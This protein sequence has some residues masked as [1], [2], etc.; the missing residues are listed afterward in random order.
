M[1]MFFE[2]VPSTLVIVLWYFGL[3]E[4]LSVAN[5]HFHFHSKKSSHDEDDESTTTPK[6]VCY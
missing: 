2:F 3:S 6:R 5:F 1:C 4:T